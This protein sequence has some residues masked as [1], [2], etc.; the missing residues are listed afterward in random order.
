M[1][2]LYWDVIKEG[3]V[4]HAVFEITEGCVYDPEISRLVGN[5]A[6][7]DG[8]CENLATKR[9]ANESVIDE[10]RQIVNQQTGVTQ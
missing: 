2:F 8:F 3:G 10:F 1:D 5:P 6:A 9:W 4:T 7:L